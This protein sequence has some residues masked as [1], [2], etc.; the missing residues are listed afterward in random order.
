MGAPITPQFLRVGSYA[1]ERVARALRSV[2]D[3]M[4]QQTC[5]PPKLV[6]RPKCVL[7]GQALAEPERPRVLS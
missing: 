3:E 1:V 5:W 4:E 2:A 7:C 6:T